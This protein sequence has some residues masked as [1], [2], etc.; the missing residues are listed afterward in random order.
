MT[1][2]ERIERWLDDLLD[3]LD[4]AARLAERGR[5]KFESDVALPLA[6]EALSNR[7]GEFAKRLAAADPVAFAEP[8]WA[9]ASRFRDAS[10]RPHRSRRAV[11]DGDT[12]LSATAHRAF[13]N[14][15]PPQNV[16]GRSRPV[17]IGGPPRPHSS[18]SAGTCLAQSP[19]RTP[20]IWRTSTP[21]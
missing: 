16:I 4:I 6:F 15:A 17:G 18:G 13:R 12:E 21:G 19:H 20:L 14:C 3:T 9:Q 10:L 5:D 7:V 1:E 8:V 11:A 2:A